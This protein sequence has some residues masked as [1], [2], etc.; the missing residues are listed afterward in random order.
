MMAL[1]DL[2]SIYKQYDSQKILQNVDFNI[3]EGERV[4]IVGKNGS[5]KSTLMKIVAGFEVQDEGNRFV[6]QGTTIEMLAQMPLFEAGVSVREAVE[7]ELTTLHEAKQKHELLSHQITQNPEDTHLLESLTKVSNF[8]DFHNAWNLDDKVERVL[9][10]FDLKWCESRDVLSLSGGEQRRVALAGLILKRPDVLLLDEPTNH[11]DVYMVKFLEEMLLGEKFTIL[12]ISHDRYFMDRLATR[13][14][15]V[16]NTG[17]RT[18][19]GGYASYIEGKELLLY[20]MAKQHDNLLKTLKVEEEW[21]ANGVRAR[22][23]RN[24]GRKDRVFAM[25]K[26]AKNN[27]ALIRKITLELEREQKAFNRTEQGKNR[28]KMLFD[29]ENISLTLGNKLL[30]ENFT[31]RILQRD[32]IAIVG[33]NGAGKSSLLKVLLSAYKIN[34][35]KIKQGEFSIGYFD[36]HREMLDDKKD[37][38]ETFCPSG[39]D[40]VDV[41][42]SNMHVFGYLKQWI[43][44][45]EYLD[46]KVGSLSGGEK[47][48]VALALLFTKKVDCLILDEPTNDLDIPTINILEE[49]LSSFDGAMIFVS[50]DRYF[51]DKI[52]SKLLV[53]KG[54]GLVQESYQS[55]SEYL[56][57][58]ESISELAAYEKSLIVQEKADVVSSIKKRSQLN[59]KEKRAYE[60]LPKEIE[61]L[62][63]EIV[64]L[65]ACLMDPKCYQHEGLSVVSQMLEDKKVLLE[66]KVEEYFVLEE[67]IESFEIES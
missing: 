55:Y 10:E 64:T 11:L 61:N 8:I 25:R 23:K 20:A 52:S 53:F 26:E 65:E 45:K 6:S 15:E 4:A 49:Y 58:E 51:V 18:F 3:N 48:R 2:Q 32:K 43:F 46:K 14:V 34:S 5:G 40:R 9:R 38:I 1:I 60:S 56:D 27:P 41:R 19:K 39:G 21:L 42:G 59:Y 28:K 54:Q 62:E 66:A 17:L 35:G 16:E 36:Q 29:L 47:N 57:I 13:T 7:Q 31:Y 37:I 30:I 33:K 24:E 63:E 50:H 12:F 44:P 67:L 22:L